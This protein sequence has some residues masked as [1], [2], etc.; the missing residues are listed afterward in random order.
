MMAR[1]ETTKVKPT[2]QK[3]ARS[4]VSDCT[5]RLKIESMNITS[6]QSVGSRLKAVVLNSYRYAQLH[7]HAAHALMFL[8]AHS[9]SVLQDVTMHY[10]HM[11]VPPELRLCLTAG[12]VTFRGV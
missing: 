4:N 2:N 6:I 1:E 5:L 12:F 10:V 3:K 9:P 8:Y 7:A 11:T